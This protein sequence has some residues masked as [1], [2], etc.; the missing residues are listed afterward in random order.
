MNKNEIISIDDKITH[1]KDVSELG[2]KSV[3]VDDI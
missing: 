1:I 2:I 3:L